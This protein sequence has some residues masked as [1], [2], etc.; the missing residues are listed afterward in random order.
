MVATTT[1]GPRPPT[2]RAR[3]SRCFAAGA[4]R[5]PRHRRGRRTSPIARALVI[6]TGSDAVVPPVPGLNELE[7]VW[8]NREVTALTEV[9]RRLLVLGG[10][11]VGVE[12]AQAVHRMGAPVALVEGME[13]VLPREPRPLGEALG[14]ALA[15]D[16]I[17]LHFGAHAAGVR[18]DGDVR[19]RVRRRDELRGDR[20]LVATGRRARVTTSASTPSA[21]SPRDRGS[22]STTAC[23]SGRPVGDRGRHRHLAPDLHGQVPRPGGR[24]EH[25]RARPHRELRG[26]PAGGVHGPPGGGRREADGAL[27]ATVPLAEV[28][29]TST[30]TRAY[31]E[32]PGF[33][34]LVPTASGSRRLRARPGGGRVAAAGH[35]RD[36]RARAASRPVRRDP[37]VPELLRGVPVHAEGARDTPETMR[38]G[39][40]DGR[41]DPG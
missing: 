35:G 1:T 34:T 11:P 9:P 3:A 22:R 36:P 27:T 14:D 39:L 28:P 2:S 16:G 21:W 40:T 31:A 38:G 13:H 32:R 37:A 33:M 25:P 30:Y 18:R 17:E 15:A 41:R 23:G 29:R 8:T 6:A 19:G 20:L 10:G 4:N 5:R 7:G 12:M 24:R 26:R